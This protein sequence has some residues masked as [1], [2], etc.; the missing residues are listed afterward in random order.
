MVAAAEHHRLSVTSRDATSY[1]SISCSFLH[2]IS[3][4]SRITHQAF[5]ICVGTSFHV[6]GVTK[7][8]AYNAFSRYQRYD[9]ILTVINHLQVAIKCGHTP[10]FVHRMFTTDIVGSK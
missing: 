6:V 8:E 3:L 1:T 10:V 4:H 5:G 7:L 2:R 9:A